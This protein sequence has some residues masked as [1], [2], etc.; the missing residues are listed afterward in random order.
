MPGIA[1]MKATNLI[2]RTRPRLY[3]I[4]GL[5]G[6][7]GPGHRAG[8]SESGREALCADAG[9]CIAGCCRS[10]GRP[11]SPKRSRAAGV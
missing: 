6:Q 11:A 1:G 4:F 5:G 7:S 2:A 10:A 3:P 8:T 9:C